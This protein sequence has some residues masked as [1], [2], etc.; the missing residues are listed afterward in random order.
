MNYF[1]VALLYGLCMHL[2]NNKR[3]SPFVQIDYF[4]LLF[5]DLA[6]FRCVQETYR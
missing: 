6:V 5:V 2:F 4:Q 3:M 1:V